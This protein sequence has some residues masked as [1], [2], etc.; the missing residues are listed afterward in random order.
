MTVSYEQRYEVEIEG[1]E[2]PPPCHSGQSPF[3]CGKEEPIWNGLGWGVEWERQPSK[4]GRTLPLTEL[5]KQTIQKLNR[6]NHSLLFEA[7]AP[8]LL[9]CHL[10][11]PRIFSLPNPPRWGC[12][13]SSRLASPKPTLHLAPT[14]VSSNIPIS[15]CTETCS[16][17][18]G[19]SPP[20]SFSRIYALLPH[21]QVHLDL[22]QRGCL[23]V[24]LLAPPHLC[25]LVSPPC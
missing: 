18:S 15:R 12:L 19:R 17:I 9:A 6:A 14:R 10:L 2:R 16:L 22:D 23:L 3:K 1:G 5:F 13:P 8:W 11:F 4:R 24:D 25:A 20:S 7:L 21:P